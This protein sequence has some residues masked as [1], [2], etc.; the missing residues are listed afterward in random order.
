[1]TPAHAHDDPHWREWAR[2]CPLGE[3]VRYHGPRFSADVYMTR[4][5]TGPPPEPDAPHTDELLL[6]PDTTPDTEGATG[7]TSP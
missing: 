5:P 6:T 4:R 7:A 2:T 1:M 3:W